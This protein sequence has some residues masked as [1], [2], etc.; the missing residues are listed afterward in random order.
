ML[1]CIVLKFHQMNR[2]NFQY[3]L[4]KLHTKIIKNK[5]HTAKSL[6]YL[7]R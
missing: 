3:I 5:Q 1:R 7:Q 6:A 2:G 4:E